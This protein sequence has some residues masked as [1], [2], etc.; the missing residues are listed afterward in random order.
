MV[1]K[2][3]KSVE[4]IRDS[5]KS[6][7]SFFSKDAA[8]E[9]DRRTLSAIERELIKIESQL[10]MFSSYRYRGADCSAS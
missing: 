8:H 4:G 3:E 1:V 10:Q 6:L 5:L 7:E 9:T 2:R